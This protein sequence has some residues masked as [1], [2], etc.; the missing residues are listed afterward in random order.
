MTPPLWRPRRPMV[1]S[2]QH[3]RPPLA[4]L[5]LWVCLLSQMSL[6]AADSSC[7][8]QDSQCSE[9]CASSDNGVC[10]DGGAHEI[11]A[12]HHACACLEFAER[13]YG[14]PASSFD[15]SHLSRTQA[16]TRSITLATLGVTA[17]TAALDARLRTRAARR[18]VSF[19][20]T[21]FATTAGLNPK[22]MIASTAQI[23]RIAAW[24]A[25]AS[26][27]R[28]QHRHGCQLQLRHQQCHPRLRHRQQSRA[29]PKQIWM[30][31]SASSALASRPCSPYRLVQ[32]SP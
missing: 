1:T 8:A 24:R 11:N 14:S 17:W 30:R 32:H 26:R 12:Q 6:V 3:R 10:N 7:E 31:P 5:G 22:P 20:T 19:T 25:V 28:R 9:T 13:R 15:V 16:T 23:A 2:T 21:G 27:R 29:Q 4:T 18:H